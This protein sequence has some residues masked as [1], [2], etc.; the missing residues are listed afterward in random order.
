MGGKQVQRDYTRRESPLFLDMR[1][2]TAEDH[3]SLGKR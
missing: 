2:M 1:E 3:T